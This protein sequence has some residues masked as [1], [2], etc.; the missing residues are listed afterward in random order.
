[1]SLT[2]HPDVAA[3]AVIELSSALRAFRDM[4]YAN[5]L[6]ADPRMTNT[7]GV[8]ASCGFSYREIKQVRDQVS[9][10]VPTLS[11]QRKAIEY[12]NQ[13]DAMQGERFYVA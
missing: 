4:E 10:H 13:L 11:A 7:K 9:G 5:A 2:Y 3:K 8:L 6:L 12:L 1:M